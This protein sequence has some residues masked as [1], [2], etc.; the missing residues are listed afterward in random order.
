M[1]NNYETISTF[2][3][4]SLYHFFPFLLL[5]QHVANVQKE[6]Y[7]KIMKQKQNQEWIFEHIFRTV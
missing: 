1:L 7:T 3:Q 6:K 5:A 4:H 2:L